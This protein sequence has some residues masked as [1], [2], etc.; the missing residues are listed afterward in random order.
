[1]PPTFAGLLDALAARFSGPPI[2][3]D[4]AAKISELPG[5][6]PPDDVV[7]HRVGAWAGTSCYST[8]DACR[9]TIKLA[10][11]IG[12]S[13]LDVIVNDDAGHQAEKSY[14]LF[15]KSSSLA[16]MAKDAGFQVHLLSWLM[17]HTRYIEGAAAALVPFVRATEVDSICFDTEE[18]WT[19]ATGNFD[20]EHAGEL[21]AQRFA[22][23]PWGVT[24]IGYASGE[25]L[26]PLVTRANYGLPQCYATSGSGLSPATAVPKL[27]GHWRKLWPSTPLVVGLAAY[28][29][30]GIPGFTEEAAV[31]AA[32]GSVQADPRITDAVYWSFGFIRNNATIQRVL[33]E[34]I[35]AQ[36]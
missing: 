2:A 3:S 24:G 18:P 29:Q 13:R 28:K 20:Y 9:R 6:Q 26:G 11:Q 21:V 10:K 1:M 12:L 23:I 32:F 16:M 8:L 14:D 31:R 4:E 33:T 34:L 15:D 5:P 30:K 35:A 17:P 27:V 25:K 19:K 36:R 22:G 7:V